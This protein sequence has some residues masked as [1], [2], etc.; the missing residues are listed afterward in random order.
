MLFGGRIKQFH[1][2]FD[3]VHDETVNAE[4]GMAFPAFLSLSK[5]GPDPDSGKFRLHLVDQGLIHER[6]RQRQV[7]KVRTQ[8]LAAFDDE[9]VPEKEPGFVRTLTPSG[10]IGECV[11][12]ILVFPDDI[13]KALE[14]GVVSM[15]NAVL[16]LNGK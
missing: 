5:I 10:C 16:E 2:S 7:P 11:A 14:T 1:G 3:I 9:T 4:P 8:I 6:A 15:C 13:E 12:L